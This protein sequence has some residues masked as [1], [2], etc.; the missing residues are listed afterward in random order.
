LRKENSVTSGD[1]TLGW[2]ERAN[3]WKYS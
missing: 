1:L 2:W 3:V